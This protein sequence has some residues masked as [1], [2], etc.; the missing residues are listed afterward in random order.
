MPYRRNYPQHASEV[1]DPEATFK[2]AAVRAVK[3]L[4]RS[5]PYRG[6]TAERQTKFRLCLEELAAAYRI[7]LPSLVFQNAE[8]RS[9]GDSCYIPASHTI[10][11]RGRLSVVTFLHEFGHARGF[12][13]RQAC[14]FSINLFAKC[15]P[16]SFASCR[17]EG[18]TLVRDE[19]ARPARRQ[20]R[21]PRRN[22]PAT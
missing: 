5:K 15:F 7:P 2:P 11:L 8:D 19:P 9:S 12:D 10:V 14:H 1:I 6:T 22:H 13:E 18:H 4:A 17:I 3:Q 16:R 20:Q 21:R